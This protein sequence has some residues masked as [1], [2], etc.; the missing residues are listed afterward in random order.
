MGIKLISFVKN[1]M[2]NYSGKGYIV[3]KRRKWWNF[4]WKHR[5]ELNDM[6]LLNRMDKLIEGLES[7][8]TKFLESLDAEFYEYAQQQKEKRNKQIKTSILLD[9]VVSATSNSLKKE[10][11]V[12][13]GIKKYTTIKVDLDNLIYEVDVA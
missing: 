9:T 6:L 12:Q 8:D 11:G 10:K 4:Y 7:G 2:L 5:K 13:Q 1:V 3:R